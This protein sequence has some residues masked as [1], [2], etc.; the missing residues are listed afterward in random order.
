MYASHLV[1][2]T[3]LT[4]LPLDSAIVVMFFDFEVLWDDL[5]S[6]VNFGD[7]WDLGSSV[8]SSSGSP[9][10]QDVGTNNEQRN[11][12]N[13]SHGSVLV[14]DWMRLKMRLMTRWKMRS[15]VG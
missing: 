9:D 3:L 10:V 15:M 14:D 6:L 7:L 8:D 13:L 4:T 11:A 2:F 5:G 1:S 12:Q